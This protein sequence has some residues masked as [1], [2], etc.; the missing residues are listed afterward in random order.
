MY[1]VIVAFLVGAAMT[2]A[3]VRRDR[4]PSYSG[5][6]LSEWLHAARPGYIN[7]AA[8]PAEATAAVRRIGTS[9]LPALL[10]WTS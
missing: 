10:K 9:A 6:S 2:A 5:H 8:P 4:E 1:L 7:P 3:F